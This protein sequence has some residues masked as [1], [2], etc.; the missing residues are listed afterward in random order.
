MTIA[1]AFSAVQIISEA[2]AQLPLNLFRILEDDNKILDTSNPLFRLLKFAPNSEMTPFEFWQFA[3]DGILLRGNSY[4]QIQRNVGGQIVALWP[5]HPDKVRVVRG[6]DGL[7]SYEYTT[8]GPLKVFKAFEIM[9]IK[10]MSKDGVVGLSP[11]QQCRES[12]GL[13]KGMESFNA[14]FFGNGAMPGIIL[15]PPQKMSPEVQ[16]EVLAAWNEHHQGA[17]KGNKAGILMPGTEVE[18]LGFSPEDSQLIESRKF[19]IQDIARIFKLP[20]HKLGSTEGVTHSN[21]EQQEL[22]FLTQTLSPHL[23]RIEQA[24]WRDLIGV[25]TSFVD[26]DTSAMLKADVE[27]RTAANS[28]GLQNGYLSINEVRQREGLNPIDDGDGYVRQL[29]LTS[30]SNSNDTSDPEPE[31]T[32]TPEEDEPAGRAAPTVSDPLMGV[33]RLPHGHSS[34]T[35]VHSEETTEARSLHATAVA[36]RPVFVKVANDILDVEAP[37]VRSA[38]NEPG[39]PVNNVKK[40]YVDHEAFVETKL[41]GAIK[42]YAEEVRKTASE[43][44]AIMG[45][46]NIDAFVNHYTVGAVSRWIIQSRKA[47]LDTLKS[48][49]DN[50]L[51][52]VSNRFKGWQGERPERFALR[53]TVQGAGAVGRET[54]KALGFKTLRWKTLGEGPSELDGKQIGIHEHFAQNGET[55]NGNQAKSNIGHPPFGPGD[56]SI[57]EPVV[58]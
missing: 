19:Q 57:I 37:G 4:T 49:P 17:N 6:S 29:N 43:S 9:H 14:S 35:P 7:L 10:G 33:E 50:A 41:Q 26:F 18:Q 40:F 3:M 45:E 56:E 8:S 23:T 32:S 15:R 30:I 12:L 58:G 21:V 54:Y 1:A 16:R 22:N 42:L 28:T 36:H 24:V 34:V 5:L 31:P 44:M 47:V 11:I 55:V 52:A 20:A 27:A 51:Q 13:T 39:D 48:N 25:E 38:L 46:M 2:V 53:E